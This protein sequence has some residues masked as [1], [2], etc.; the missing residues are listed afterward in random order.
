MAE[1]WARHFGGDRVAAELRI[2]GL[3]DLIAEAFTGE[4]PA[5]GEDE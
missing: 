1:G 3:S 2:L 4:M 5:A